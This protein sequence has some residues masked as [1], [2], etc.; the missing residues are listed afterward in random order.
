MN[1]IKNATN[2]TLLTGATVALSAMAYLALTPQ[3]EQLIHATGMHGARSMALGLTATM[4]AG[5]I[6]AKMWKGGGAAMSWAILALTVCV[7]LT[8]AN[9]VI[10]ELAKADA[11]YEA[12]VATYE[13]KAEERAK[14]I[15]KAEAKA[16]RG[17]EKKWP[18]LRKEAAAELAVARALP[19]PQRPAKPNASTLTMVV[20]I[21][22]PA[23]IEAVTATILK[24][25]GNALGA[26]WLALLAPLWA[27]RE[28]KPTVEPAAEPAKRTVSKATRKKI[29]EG[30]K[31]HHAE[32]K[33]QAALENEENVIA[34][35]MAMVTDRV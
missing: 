26:G 25:I 13:T 2:A 11:A 16:K 32:K 22:G 3:L 19:V 7:A 21:A 31:R 20:S 17:E 9:V 18:R 4:I 5:A 15:A 23:G 10:D 30:L 27:K 28:E 14:A 29:S 6:A 24:L 34:L 35:P 1:A 33:R 8:R 12:A